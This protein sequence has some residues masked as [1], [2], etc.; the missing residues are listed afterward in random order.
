MLLKNNTAVWHLLKGFK[1][2]R[3]NNVYSHKPAYHK[4]LSSSVDIPI[5]EWSM[6]NHVGDMVKYHSPFKIP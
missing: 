5:F 1:K 6:N 3:V 4:I 2:I